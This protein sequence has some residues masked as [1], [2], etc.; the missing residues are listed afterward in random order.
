M[1]F[2][3]YHRREA[4]NPFI[5]QKWTFQRYWAADGARA[6]EFD[7]SNINLYTLYW[8]SFLLGQLVLV[9]AI[10]LLS[11]STLVSLLFLFNRSPTYMFRCQWYITNISRC[12]WYITHMWS[13]APLSHSSRWKQVSR[14]KPPKSQ[15]PDEKCYKEEGEATE[16]SIG[17]G[18]GKSRT[19]AMAQLKDSPVPARFPDSLNTPAPPLLPRHPCKAPYWTPSSSPKNTTEHDMGSRTWQQEIFVRRRKKHFWYG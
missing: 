19:K 9:L 1:L 18:I 2:T 8:F 11:L 5:Q 15:S 13:F 7:P 3:K 6:G 17:H 4:W 16:E 12:Q 14:G 10:C